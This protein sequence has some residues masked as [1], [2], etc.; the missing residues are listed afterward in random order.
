MY[1]ICVDQLLSH[2]YSIAMRTLYASEQGSCKKSSRRLLTNIV[3]KCARIWKFLLAKEILLDERSIRCQYYSEKCNTETNGL[4]GVQTD[5]IYHTIENR[6]EKRWR[7]VQ[8]DHHRQGEVVLR[9]SKNQAMCCHDHIS[10]HLPLEVMTWFEGQVYSIEFG[11]HRRNY[12]DSDASDKTWESR[13]EFLFVTVDEPQKQEGR[14]ERHHEY[15]KYVP[16]YPTYPGIICIEH[17][18]ISM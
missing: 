2:H 16:I 1:S 8:S 13:V 14:T 4:F 18:V 6:S 7:V 9:P 15:G 11:Y 12:R 3:L 10:Q 5:P 17:L